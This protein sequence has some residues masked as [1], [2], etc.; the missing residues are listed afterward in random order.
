MRLGGVVHVAADEKAELWSKCDGVVFLSL[1]GV[2]VVV[3]VGLAL[4][5][6]QYLRCR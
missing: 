2:V 4:D 1:L 6:C 5:I 3:L